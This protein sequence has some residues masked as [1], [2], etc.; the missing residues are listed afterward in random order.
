[1]SDRRAL[2]SREETALQALEL[3]TRGA[4]DNLWIGDSD[5]KH[6]VNALLG[7]TT[8]SPGSAGWIEP[9]LN[10]LQLTD[11]HCRKI[12]SGGHVYCLNRDEVLDMMR[13]YEVAAIEL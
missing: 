4:E 2:N 8:E 5:L 7:L 3:L 6:Q 10:R 1:M 12:C 9:V 11:R 13:R